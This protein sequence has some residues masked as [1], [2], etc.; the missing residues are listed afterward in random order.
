MTPEEIAEMD[1]RF[2]LVRDRQKEKARARLR[3]VAKKTLPN[4]SPQHRHDVVEKLIE[5]SFPDA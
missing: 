3:K 4:A 5:T 1:A 2:N